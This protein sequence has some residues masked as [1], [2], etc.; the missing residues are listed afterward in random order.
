MKKIFL[1]VLLFSFS[2]A[3]FSQDSGTEDFD[4][5]D[6]LFAEAEDIVVEEQA[7]APQPVPS[8]QSIQ[9]SGSLSS[10]MGAGFSISPAFFCSLNCLRVSSEYFHIFCIFLYY[11]KFLRVQ[12]SNFFNSSAI[13]SF[14][15]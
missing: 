6:S 11:Q 5:L 8:K 3:L 7:T 15:V 1:F 4:D 12:I 14:T 10:G 2:I 9:F 13:F